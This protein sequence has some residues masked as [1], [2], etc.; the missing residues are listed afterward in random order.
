MIL[1]WHI[2]K[3]WYEGESVDYYMFRTNRYEGG[4]CATSGFAD[5]CIEDKETDRLFGFEIKLGGADKDVEHKIKV[6]T[7][8]ILDKI[9]AG[10]HLSNEINY[11]DYA[12]RYRLDKKTDATERKQHDRRKTNQKSQV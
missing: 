1:D 10:V 8:D 5:I 3:V 4:F 7:E 9:A 12:R 2:Q 11:A 6:L